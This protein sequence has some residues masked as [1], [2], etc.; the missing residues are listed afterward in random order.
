[1]VINNNSVRIP[2]RIITKDEVNKILIE[3]SKYLYLNSFNITL[4]NKINQNWKFVINYKVNG[5]KNGEKVII[6]DNFII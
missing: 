3:I 6:N 1:M 2:A 5:Q 4:S